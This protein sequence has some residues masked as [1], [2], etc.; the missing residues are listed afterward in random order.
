[1]ILPRRLA[2]LI[3]V[4][5]VLATRTGV[6]QTSPPRVGLLS[7]GTNPDRPTNWDPFFEAMA[8]HGYVDGRT[9]TFERRFARGQA[10]LIPGMAEDLVRQKVAAIVA[11][12]WLENEALRRLTSTIP[13][14]MVAV[15]DPVASKFVH[16]LSRPGG[17]MTGVTLR[18]PGLTD[19][20]LQLLKEVVPAL[21]RVGVLVD[22]GSPAALAMVDEMQPAARRL[23]IV[24][25]RADIARR[26]DI[27]S[28]VAT[29]SRDGVGAVVVS[30]DAIAF[31]HREFLAT[32]MAKYR[33]PALYGFA[34]QA[35]AGGL[36]SYGAYFPDNFRRAASFVDRIL[37][38]AR[39]GEL[40]V[41][42]PTKIEL[43]INLKTARALG[44]TLP[45]SITA[46][47]DRVIE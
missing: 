8:Q 36:I 12:G 43:A 30:Q 15:P 6:A 29:L 23:G 32:V 7:S 46:R 3:A 44:L 28:A 45:P 9:I 1:V 37:K 13:V 41:E 2:V 14:V 20:Y 42:Q 34:E 19:K 35:E 16:S 5:A 17:N 26:E 22:P 4:W 33:L 47:A 21:T 10:A 18:V 38:G 27:E 24:L 25:R 40:P 11:T 39:P 31:L